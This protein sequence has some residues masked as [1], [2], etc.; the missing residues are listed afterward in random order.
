MANTFKFGNK[1]WYGK[2]GSVLA[3]NDENNNFKPL[4][5]DFT[6]SSSATRVNKDGLIEVVGSDEPRVDYLNN[7]D[8]HLLLEPQRKNDVPYSEDT[9]GYSHYNY[10]GGLIVDTY[11]YPSP[12]G[13]NNASRL[14]YTNSSAGSG[15]ALLT[16]NITLNAT[17]TYTL[18]LWIKSISGLKKIRVS[19]KDTGS[20]GPSGEVF[21]I[22][23]EW[24]RYTHTFTNDGGTSRGFQFRISE[25][26]DS[27]DRTFDVWGMQ[28]EEGSYATSYIPTSGSSVTRS[29]DAFN[30]TVPDNIFGSTEGVVFLEVG[31]INNNYVTGA[32][33][34]F[35][36]IRK[37][38]NNSF[39]IGS[40]GADTA[41]AIR[42]VTQISGALSTDAEPSGF[43]DSKIAIQ[44]TSSN[45]KIYQN[46]SLVATVNKSIGDYSEVEFFEGAGLD[47]RMILKDFRIYNA[48]LT[49]AQLIALT[50]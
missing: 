14:V 40:G 45:F 42:F 6:R 10:G 18:S 29:V 46:G 34:W 50:S 38:A 5:F 24:Q 1:Q 16:Q 28:I 11:G 35:M 2:K 39:G 20:S 47:L 36:E 25:T 26:E 43:S 12:D 9:T 48:T 3:Y 19:P 23:N 33:K 37:D 7:A 44:Y 8:G 49:D 41:P 32:S 31:K 15:G 21:T 27:G 13:G 22:T 17:G 30:Q 4:P